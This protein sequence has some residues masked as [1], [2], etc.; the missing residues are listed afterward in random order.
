MQS[1]IFNLK[2]EKKLLKDVLISYKKNKINTIISLIILSLF[3]FSTT[4]AFSIILNIIHEMTA[5]NN[6]D[7]NKLTIQIKILV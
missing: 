6:I 5:K 2:G 1:L 3:I 7:N 4:I